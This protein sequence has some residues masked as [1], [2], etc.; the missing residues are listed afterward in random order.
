MSLAKN[1]ILNMATNNCYLYDCHEIHDE[2]LKVIEK[3]NGNKR[4][5][6]QKIVEHHLRVLSQTRSSFV[7]ELGYDSHHKLLTDIFA[8]LFCQ[9]KKRK[10]YNE[11]GEIYVTFFAMQLKVQTKMESY[12]DYTLVELFQLLDILERERFPTESLDKR[13]TEIVEITAKKL[14]VEPK[15]IGWL[16]T[17]EHQRKDSEREDIIRE[18]AEQAH[19]DEKCWKL[20][21][22]KLVAL[23]SSVSR[24]GEHIR[25]I[26]GSVDKLEAS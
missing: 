24:I 14:D 2:L 8:C 6:F 4:H 5:I 20:M 12:E 15:E 3:Y 23:A 13:K 26:R 9:V 25:C 16:L 17:G 7:G 1:V 18:K 11:D 22:R 21:T 10:K 19:E